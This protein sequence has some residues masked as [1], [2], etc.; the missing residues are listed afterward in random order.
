MTYAERAS[1]LEQ[2]LDKSLTALANC[3]P[4]TDEYRNLVGGLEA[5]QWLSI[6]FGSN[7]CDCDSCEDG[8]T[9]EP[10][11]DSATTDVNNCSAEAD[12]TT[13][14]S[15][16]EPAPAPSQ[17]EE[18]INPEDLRADLHAAKKKGVDVAKLIR[19]LGVSNFTALKDDQGKLLQLRSMLAA[20]LEE[21][22]V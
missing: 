13:T 10:N 3:R 17:P 7:S 1:L 14:D 20:A 5:L 4:G 15:V 12:F 19:S 11:A 8:R 9:S 2:V 18:Y 21:L 6:R 16:L 22:G